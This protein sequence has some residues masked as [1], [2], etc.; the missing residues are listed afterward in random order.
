[1]DERIERCEI[2]IRLHAK[3]NEAAHGL[4]AVTGIGPITA[5]AVVA[6]VGNAQDFRNGRQMAA[7]AGLCP[8]VELPGKD[9]LGRITKRGDPTFAR[10]SPG[11][12]SAVQSALNRTPEKRSQLEQ[13]IVA[14]RH[15]S[16]T[17][18]HWWLSP[19]NLPDPLGH[20]G[21]RGV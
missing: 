13:S 4:T 12:R 8:T 11:Y 3:G 16:A 14:L 9:A 6:T 15:G 17:T 5:S 7:W 21:Q 10:Y 18:K 19:T 20:P 1:M 2:R